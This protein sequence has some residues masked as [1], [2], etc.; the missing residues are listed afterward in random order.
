[1]TRV[2]LDPPF[3]TRVT[4]C[5]SI[6]KKNEIFAT[7]LTPWINLAKENIQMATRGVDGLVFKLNSLYMKQFGNLKNSA[8]LSF[9]VVN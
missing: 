6:E 4:L 2:A 9:G 3:F 1:M 7:N 5:M 8:K